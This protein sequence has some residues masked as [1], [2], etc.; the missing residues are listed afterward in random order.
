MK[1]KCILLFLISGIVLLVATGRSFGVE[2]APEEKEGYIGAATCRG[3]HENMYESYMRSVHSKKEAHGPEFKEACET[4]HGP[5]AKHVEK[6]GGRGVNI[7]DFGKRVD[8]VVRSEKCLTCHEEM[9]TNAFWNMSRHKNGGV[10]C[11]DCHIVH[12]EKGKF[13]QTPEPELCFGCHKDV[14][15]QS[16]KQSHHPL[17]GLS[18]RGAKILCSNCHDVHG[19]FGEKMIK[20]DSVNELCYT[21][22][23]EKRGPFMWEHPPVEENCLT[24]HT[25]HGSNHSKLLISRPPELCQSCHDWTQHPGTPYTQFETFP[26]TAA[27]GKN[28]LIARSC[29]NCH[30]QIHGSNGPSTRGLRFVR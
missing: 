26:G 6:G 15:A 2:T 16:H 18:T 10:A 29:L 24:C 1:K 21:C 14:K 8:P 12:S 20:A 25:P 11:N 13:L 23:A 5:G 7:V 17:T 19:G 30:S 27:S 3:C 22:H 28:R 4:C 9:R